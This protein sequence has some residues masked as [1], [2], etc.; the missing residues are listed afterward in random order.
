MQKF[1]SYLVFGPN[2]IGKGT[3][4]KAVGVL[5]GFWHFSTGDM[6]RALVARV[7]EG[8][9]SELELKIDK[10]MKSG[11]LVD[12]QTTV[13]LA[14]QNLEQ[15]A[16]CDCFNVDT[17]Y[18]L[19]D[20]LPRNRKQ[21]EMIT[22]FIDV[23]GVLHVTASREVAVA[24]ITGR[25]RIEGRKDDQDEVAVG[26]RLDIFFNNAT[27]ILSYY[28]PGYTGKDMTYSSEMIHYIN[29]EQKPA[30]VLRDFL[31]FIV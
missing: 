22:P 7:K 2:G 27:D 30:A 3:N 16:S 17:D 12:D 19:L 6:F 29:A 20:G 9:A 5:P 24:R 31:S 4:A 26:K 18:L 1:K 8:K 13:D 11:G 14:Q 25:A 28:D 15:A 10:V 23:V 21:A